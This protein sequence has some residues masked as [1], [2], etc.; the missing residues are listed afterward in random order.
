MPT[1]DLTDIARRMEAIGLA[2]GQEVNPDLPP[3]PWQPRWR[4]DSRWIEFECGC[5][6]ERCMTL[7][8]VRNTDPIIFA[9]TAQQAVYD[10]ACA[11]HMPGM[12]KWIGFGGRGLDFNQW[13][14]YRRDILMGKVRR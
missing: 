3:D 5:R 11:R 4:I 12:N 10:F 1:D 14:R 8:D 7:R 13:R 6:A 2:S 9:G